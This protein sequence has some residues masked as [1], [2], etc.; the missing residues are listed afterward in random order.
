M[1]KLPEDVAGLVERLEGDIAIGCSATFGDT[2]LAA[3][4]IRALVAK[5]DAK[6]EECSHAWANWQEERDR[7]NALE[8]QVHE[9][10]VEIKR[11]REWV[12]VCNVERKERDEAQAKLREAVEVMHR[13][14]PYLDAIVN[15]ASTMDEYEPNRI[16][17][18][19][20]AFLATMEKHAVEKP[21]C[22]CERSANGLGISGRECDCMEKPRD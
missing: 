7:V 18:D 5:F 16:A 1:D 19:A 22:D 8:A 2:M 15:Y 3:S 20:R 14:E 11:L 21:I 12:A 9:Q 6:D 13:I 4:T 10:A 17:Y